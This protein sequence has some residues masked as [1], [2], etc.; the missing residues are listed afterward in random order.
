MTKILCTLPPSYRG[1]NT[2]WDSVPATE[3][4][5]ALLTSRPLKEEATSKRY[6]RGLPDAQDVAFFAR[7]SFSS[8]QPTQSHYKVPRGGRTGRGSRRGGSN[9]QRPFFQ[10]EYCKKAWHTQSECRIRIRNEAATKTKDNKTSSQAK[11]DEQDHCFI[12]STICFA[13]RCPI[14]WFADSRA[15]QHMSDQ[16]FCFTNYNNVKPDTW[17]VNGIVG[18]SLS[19]HGYGDVKLIATVDRV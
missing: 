12:S 14:D 4:T 3:R 2:S 6:S 1:F 10:C 13:A 9:R 8:V 19:V 5:M 11:S 16:Q 18:A 15:T 7:N 17:I